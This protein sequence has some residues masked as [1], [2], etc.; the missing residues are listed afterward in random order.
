MLI[1]TLATI[2]STHQVS[3]T[4]LF[5]NVKS[6]VIHAQGFPFIPSAYLPTPQPEW[7]QPACMPPCQSTLLCQPCGKEPSRKY[8]NSVQIRSDISKSKNN[9]R[10]EIRIKVTKNHK[11][12][13]LINFVLVFNQFVL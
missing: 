7:S 5:S 6:Y 8:P 11:V 1:H 4:Q 12:I 10:N 13:F 2:E 3:I 9:T